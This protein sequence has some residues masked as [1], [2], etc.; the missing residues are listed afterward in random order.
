[1]AEIIDLC[2]YRKNKQ[3][4]EINRLREELAV[5]IEEMGGIHS[6][7]IYIMDAGQMPG[8]MDTTADLSQTFYSNI[9][10]WTSWTWSLDDKN[11][12]STKE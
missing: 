7:P 5:L 6:V 2:E 11:D 10:P 9:P 12:D 4:D 8:S 1:M 3:E